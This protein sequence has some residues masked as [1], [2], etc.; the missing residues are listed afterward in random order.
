MN[1]SFVSQKV[2]PVS[3][4]IAFLFTFLFLYDTIR[5]LVWIDKF[6]Y[7]G[8]FF[9]P[10]LLLLFLVSRDKLC[11]LDR[12]RFG[13]AV[14][15]SAS[16]CLTTI[17]N[18]YIMAQSWLIVTPFMIFMWGV[19]V[20]GCK[21]S[22]ADIIY[23]LKILT[24]I[25]IAYCAL[26]LF[27]N[28]KHLFLFWQNSKYYL[29]ASAGVFF[30]KNAWGQFLMPLIFSNVMLLRMDKTNKKYWFVTLAILL[31]NLLASLSRTAIIA[32]VVLFV[33]ILAL[34]FLH[35]QRPKVRKIFLYVLPLVLSLLILAFIPQMQDFLTHNFLKINRI[36]SDRGMIWL[37]TWQ[38]Y[39]PQLPFWGFGFGSQAK[40][41]AAY[42]W[43]LNSFHDIYLDWL[44][45]GGIIYFAANVFLYWQSFKDAYA[46]YRES[47]SIGAVLLAIL[48]AFLFY[49]SAEEVNL[50]TFATSYL[51]LCFLLFALPHLLRRNYCEN[52]LAAGSPLGSGD[53]HDPRL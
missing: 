52:D 8:I 10:Q 14:L 41:L 13:A 34:D 4:G 20:P 53:G 47:S 29:D 26:N 1:K 24:G 27:I 3:I 7:Y 18:N 19:F 38:N 49:G 48:A 5:Y 9:L 2:S 16:F 44:L 51:L 33:S 11:S 35:A 15:L 37:I 36:L 6:F 12:Q 23:I 28:Q 32:V 21:I 17:I 40:L 22:Y 50:F 43:E 30:N 46:V 25:G 45:Q 42:G 39:L 31:Y